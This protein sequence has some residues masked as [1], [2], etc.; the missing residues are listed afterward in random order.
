MSREVLINDLRA[1]GAQQIEA[2]WREAREE[3]ERYRAESAALVTVERNSCDLSGREATLALHRQRA[4]ATRRQTGEIITR[5]EQ[6]LSD[7]L[8][9]LAR[10]LLSG[11]DWSGDRATL[12]ADL[13][14]EL[15]PGSWDRVR[16]NPVDAVTASQLFPAAEIVADQEV[17]GGLEVTGQDGSVTIDNTLNTRLDRVWPRLIPELLQE[18]RQDDATG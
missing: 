4:M 9:E 6:Q 17:L 10:N 5:A 18:L 3:L 16:V 2:L 15:P 7:R 1:K 14:A 12:L 11:S 8:Y 13:T